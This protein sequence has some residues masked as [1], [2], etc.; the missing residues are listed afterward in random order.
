MTPGSTLN[1]NVASMTSFSRLLRSWFPL[2]RTKNSVPSESITYPRSQ[3]SPHD[4]SNSSLRPTMESQHRPQDAHDVY[5]VSFL[6]RQVLVPDLIPPILDYAEYWPKTTSSR[7]DEQCYE[8][9][10]SAKPHLKILVPS[11][12]APRAVRQVE[13]TITSHDQGWSSYPQWHGTYQG[14]WTWFEAEL[15]RPPQY[16]NDREGEGI[17]TRREL[18]RNVHADK[19]PKTHV[20]KWRYDAE[21]EEE[22][23][24]V[25]ALKAKDLISVIPFAMFPGWQNH[26]LSVR[27]DIYTAA[28]RRM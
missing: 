1:P 12:T 4:T 22:R 23:F 15:P 17:H 11:T 16:D 18:C 2:R 5:H 24:L 8:Q 28:V 27:V 6:L 3:N 21:D 14:S 9:F 7:E 19:R 20:V 25:R 26:V 13:F 10:N